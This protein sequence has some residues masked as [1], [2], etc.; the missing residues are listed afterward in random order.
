[1][2]KCLGATPSPL[3]AVLLRSSYTDV[4]GFTTRLSDFG[5]TRLVA[6]ADDTAAPRAGARHRHSGTV[7]HMPPELLR[8]PPGQ[9]RPILWSHSMFVR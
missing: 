8:V 4:R 9:V 7:T 1:M 5:L 2:Y 6:T 3:H